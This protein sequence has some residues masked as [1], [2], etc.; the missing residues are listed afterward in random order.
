MPKSRIRNVHLTSADNRLYRERCA[1]HATL[2][3]AGKGEREAD[4]GRHV[5]AWAE[6]VA[7]AILGRQFEQDGRNIISWEELNAYGHYTRKFKETDGLFKLDQGMLSV[8]VKASFS[9]ASVRKGRQQINDNLNLLR[10]I[11]GRFCG[12]LILFDCSV[13]NPDL[14]A[15][16]PDFVQHLR[17]SG[18][19]GIL[20]GTDWLLD[21]SQ[22]NQWL[23]LLDAPQVEQLMAVYG[24]PA[25][26][27]CVSE[28]IVEY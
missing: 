12:L 16:G 4:T 24:P 6:R 20:Q 1:Y 21:T 28:A 22:F 8:E 18:E 11:R 15:R 19:Y 3:R 17:N 7:R 25:Q 9:Q 26:G 13:I 27:E 2:H 10:Q 14:V 5:T 23:W